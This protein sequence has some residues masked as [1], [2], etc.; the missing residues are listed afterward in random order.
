MDNNAISRILWMQAI[1]GAWN[2][3]IQRMNRILMKNEM[4]SY[5]SQKIDMGMTLEEFAESIFIAG[6]V[7]G[8]K[9]NKN[10]MLGNQKCEPNLN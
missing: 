4:D 6:F 8:E 5:L 10:H 2:A 1:K 7:A 3:Y 9:Y